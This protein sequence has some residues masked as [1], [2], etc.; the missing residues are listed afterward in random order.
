MEFFS[1]TAALCDCLNELKVVAVDAK[2]S[3]YVYNITHHSSS[4]PVFGLYIY[5]YTCAC[6]HVYI[7]IYIRQKCRICWC[8]S[9]SSSRSPER[10]MSAVWSFGI[11]EKSSTALGAFSSGGDASTFVRILCWLLGFNWGFWGR[12]SVGQWSGGQYEMT[13]GEVGVARC[14]HLRTWSTMPRDS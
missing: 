2:S 10:S 6:I 5:A 1:T 14:T 7:Y 4:N 8:F 12:V 9:H 11:E 13:C 3:T